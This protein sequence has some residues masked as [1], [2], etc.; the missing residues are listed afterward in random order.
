MQKE[1]DALLEFRQDSLKKAMDTERF[2]Y[3]HIHQDR[4]ERKYHYSRSVMSK[5]VEE[6]L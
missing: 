4:Y 6:S 3:G 1:T 5:H 2:G